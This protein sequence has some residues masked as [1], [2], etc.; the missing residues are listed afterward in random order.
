MKFS[1]F[2][3]PIAGLV[4]AC[5]APAPIIDAPIASRTEAA[6]FPEKVTPPASSPVATPKTAPQPAPSVPAAISPVP[7]SQ[8]PIG[9]DLLD[10]LLPGKIPDR[11]GWTNDIFNAFSALQLQQSPEN[12]CAAIAVIEQL[13]SW[14]SDPVVPNLGQKVWNEIGRRAGKYHVPLLAVQAALSVPSR[15]GRSYKARIDALRTEKQMNELFEDIVNE[16]PDLACKFGITNPIRTGGP[17]QVGIDFARAH[18]N[19]WRYP[20]PI[21]DS[22]RHEVFTRRGGVYF[23]IAHLLQYPIAYQDMLH[24]FADYNAGRYTSRNVAFQLAA[25]RLGKSKI[26]PDGD[27]LTY[28]N[29]HPAKTKSSTEKALLGIS[30]KLGLSASE[31][32]S[33]LSKEKNAAFGQS[34]LYQRVFA[35]ADQ[36]A[37]KPLPREAMPQIRLQG[38]KITSKLTTEWFASRVNGRYRQCLVRQ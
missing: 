5:A 19:S 10:R 8:E 24:R 38:A 6:P 30:G 18:V 1:L 28:E 32:A 31:I 17:M 33:D 23:G 34:K 11:S 21:K 2:L 16:A 22:I 12:F 26:T 36:S 9:R 4:V 7:V 27:L 35:L 15:E 29:G 20:Y 14:Q 25:T 3:L 13:S 37:G